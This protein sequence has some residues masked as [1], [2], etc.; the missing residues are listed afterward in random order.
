MKILVSN[1]FS[2]LTGDIPP[3]ATEMVREV[4][5]YKRD[6]FQEKNQLINSIRWAK[7]SLERVHPEEAKAYNQ[8][9][10]KLKAFQEAYKKLLA[11]E[12]VCWFEKN[13]FPTGHLNLVTAALEDVKVSFKIEDGRERPANSLILRWHNNPYPMRYYQ[14]NAVKGAILAERGVIESAVGT[15]KSLMMAYLVKHYALTTLIVVPSRALLDQLSNDFKVWFGAEKVQVIDTKQ[16]RK[17]GKLKPIRITTIQS[18]AALQKSDELSPLVADVDLLLVDEIHHA[19]ADSYLNLLSEIEH[20]YHRFG[21]T[22]LFKRNDESFLDMWGFLSNVIF[23]Y[24]AKQAIADGFLTPATVKMYAL[25]GNAHRKYQ[26]EYDLNYSTNGAFYRL[27][28]EIVLTY[29]GDQVLILVKK[30]DKSG[31]LIHEYLKKQ[32]IDSR[33]ISGDDKKEVISSTIKEF[34]EKK[35]DV[36]IGSGVIGEGVDVCSTD[37]L[38]NAVGGK[39]EQ[40]LVQAVGRGIRLYPDKDRAYIHDPFFEDTKYMAKHATMRMDVYERNFGCQLERIPYAG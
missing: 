11:S 10:A 14:E 25:P 22:G 20:I 29:R 5:T 17:S 16:V 24:P 40:V 38:I 1:S 7:Q 4:L 12:T 8:Q 9:Q 37:H 2:K 35:F 27:I 36:M 31:L 15:G 32:G 13:T 23:T 3:I 18:M 6:I 33:Y 28:R 26:T 34:N 19:G 39:S 30:K 21:F